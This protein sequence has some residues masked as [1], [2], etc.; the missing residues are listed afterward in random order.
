VTLPTPAGR[1]GDPPLIKICGLTRR[2]DV[3]LAGRL[4]ARFV[5][6]ILAGGPRQLSEDEWRRVVGGAREGVQRVAVVGA[7]PVASVQ[8]AARSTA[9]DL[10][11][12]HGDPSADAIRAA[13]A[14]GL[15]VWPVLRIDGARLPRAAWGLAEAAGTL[16]LDAKV[17]GQLGG[18]GV[19]LPWDALADD[20]AR[21]RRDLPGA[22]LVL[23]GGLRPENVARAIALLGP[24]VVD[25]S[26]G[27][28][29]APGRKDPDRLRA[30]V[31]AVQG[32][33]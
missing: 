20:V 1:R 22:T 27:V 12:W 29:A 24:D 10:V 28:E 4:G 31:H 13:A 9:C 17:P 23:A 30:F 32:A 16:V 2:E 15:T 18:T 7:G 19:A 11:Q 6:G 3:D 26:S 21:W 5:G 14:A 33:S 8:D 25:V